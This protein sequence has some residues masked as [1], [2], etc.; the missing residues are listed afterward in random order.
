M[1]FVHYPIEGQYFAFYYTDK[2]IVNYVYM[3][4]FALFTEVLLPNGTRHSVLTS[5]PARKCA[6]GLHRM[7]YLIT[8]IDLLSICWS[9]QQQR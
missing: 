5:D 7:S 9:V 6:C 2:P 1:G 3:Q 4:M 8:Q